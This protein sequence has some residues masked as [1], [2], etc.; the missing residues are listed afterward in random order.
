MLNTII[1]MGRITHSLELKTVSG[2]KS[3]LN[4]SVAVERAY[5]KE[6]ITDFFDCVAWNNTA[7]FISKYF[8]KGDMIAV[9]G[10]MTT[11]EYTGKDGT[12]KRAFEILVERASFCAGKK[13][14]AVNPEDVMTDVKPIEG[15]V[16]EDLPF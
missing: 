5:G 6:K 4:F 2:D 3:V 12:K 11:R 1:I 15:S 8:S 7:N 16:D 13:E 14:Q 9:T 10:Q